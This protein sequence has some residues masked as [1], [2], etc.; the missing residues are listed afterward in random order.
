MSVARLE[1][2]LKPEIYEMVKQAAQITGRT[3]TDFVAASL[4][5]EAKKTIEEYSMI[6]LSLADQERFLQALNQ[7]N[8]PNKAMKKAEERHKLLIKAN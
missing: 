2:R 5:A 4:Y 1:T 7:P 6:K 8:E 3:I